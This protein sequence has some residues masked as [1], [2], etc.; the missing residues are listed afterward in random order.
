[1]SASLPSPRS[2]GKSFR[3]LLLRDEVTSRKLLRHVALPRKVPETTARFMEGSPVL[4]HSASMCRSSK[5]CS[6][7]SCKKILI[8]I[9]NSPHPS[10]E[11]CRVPSSRQG[12]KAGGG[13]QSTRC[14]QG[15]RS[16]WN[17]AVS[18]TR[19]GL[20]KEGWSWKMTRSMR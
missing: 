3:A 7:P 11:T 9:S 4:G 12:M 18:T 20:L 10:S 16:T 2:S 6:G 19:V 5:P 13:T 8:A 15:E 17:G 14:M 1:M